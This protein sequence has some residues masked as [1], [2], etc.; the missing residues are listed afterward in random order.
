MNN[1]IKNHLFLKE[2]QFLQ[3]FKINFL[4]QINLLVHTN[5]LNVLL[6]YVNLAQKLKTFQKLFLNLC[7]MNLEILSLKKSYL[8]LL[9]LMIMLLLLVLKYLIKKVITQQFLT[10]KQWEIVFSLKN[11]QMKHVLT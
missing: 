5:S 1:L 9:I 4:L 3:L 2:L 11:I 7:K 10:K 6:I 8:R